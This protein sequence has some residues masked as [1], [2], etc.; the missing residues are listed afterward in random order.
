MTGACCPPA[1]PG[2]IKVGSLDP[3]EPA[4]TLLQA[5][6]SATYASG[7][8]LFARDQTLMAQAF[9]PDGVN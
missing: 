5:D 2:A 6:S 1:K 3:A 7:H 9:D 8:M 4:V